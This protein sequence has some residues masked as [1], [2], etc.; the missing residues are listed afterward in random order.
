MD[1]DNCPVCACVGC[2]ICMYSSTLGSFGNSAEAWSGPEFLLFQKRSAVPE[3]TRYRIDAQFCVCVFRPASRRRHCSFRA[4][5]L[6]LLPP[7]Y[8]S[9]LERE[10]WLSAMRLRDQS[11]TGLAR[12]RPECQSLIYNLAISC[13]TYLRQE[14]RQ[15]KQDVERCRFSRA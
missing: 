2:A 6:L 4:C 9:R 10:M 11:C 3:K 14:A 8:F 5:T 13:D 1:S 7:L 15:M 12:S